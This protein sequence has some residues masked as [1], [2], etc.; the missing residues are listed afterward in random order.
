MSTFHLA[1]VKMDFFRSVKIN[2]GN[3]KKSFQFVRIDTPGNL[4]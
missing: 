3:G 2:K 4:L 1:I